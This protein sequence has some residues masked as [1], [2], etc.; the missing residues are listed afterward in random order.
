MSPRRSGNTVS[1]LEPHPRNQR[2]L[3]NIE[4]IGIVRERDRQPNRE[5]LCLKRSSFTL[6]PQRGEVDNVKDDVGELPAVMSP[7]S[8]EGFQKTVIDGNSD[9]LITGRGL[10]HTAMRRSMDAR[11][12]S[13][14]SGGRSTLTVPTKGPSCV[15]G[16]LIA[17]VL[18]EALGM[19]NY[20]A[21]MG[22]MTG[23]LT[24]RYSKPTPLNTESQDRGSLPRPR[25]PQD[26]V[27]GWNLP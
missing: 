13:G 2:T 4:N 6:H 15:H 24:V 11:A 16:G 19:A 20:V 21:G 1:L 10:G 27:L 14:R 23:T 7:E 18:D 22:A 5:A 25:G 12:A 8:I 17:A 26:P 9:P 3:D